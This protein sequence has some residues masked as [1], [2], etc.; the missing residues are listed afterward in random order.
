MEIACFPSREIKLSTRSDA[1]AA[2]PSVL[3]PRCE[4]HEIPPVFNENKG[5]KT[6][7]AR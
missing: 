7:T 1:G 3:A 2:P 4:T 6:K 5:K